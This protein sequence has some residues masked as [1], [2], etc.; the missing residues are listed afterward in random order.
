MKT[1]IYI[2]NK[3]GVSANANVSSID[4]LAPLLVENGFRIYTASNK[5]NI[6]FR[7]LDM[8]WTCFKYRKQ[9]DYVLIDTYSTLN[10]YYAFFVSQLCRALKLKYLP[11]LHGGHLPERIKTSPKLSEA[12]FSNAYVNIAPSEYAK[13][14]F[15]SFGYSNIVCIPN[16]IEI[17]S[18]P[19]LK[20]RFESIALLWVR[21]FSKI[22]NPLLAIKIL[23]VFKD[24][25]IEAKL[26]M[27]GPDSDGSL[28]DAKKYADKLDVDV[29]FTGKLSK[30]E[31]IKLSEKYN[32]FINTT[33]A[34]NMPLSVIEAMALGLPIVS[35]NV[36]GLP[37]FIEH[38]ENGILVNPNSEDAFVDSII[39][40][41]NKPIFANQLVQ[42]ARIKA[43]NLDW[44]VIKK[45]WIKVLK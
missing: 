17:K 26:C 5:K 25:N 7:L 41:M 9:T 27:V 6:V 10:F 11:I 39:H 32:F 44:E 13:S 36:G 4:V 29:Y 21:S 23:K 16:S 38:H 20:R 40:L 45:Q 15:E 35:T 42:Q 19:F 31:W 28:E 22:Y 24:R 30:H 43:E 3:S 2:G 37:F 34:D 14:N 33:N 1:V 18:Y 12:I 8:L